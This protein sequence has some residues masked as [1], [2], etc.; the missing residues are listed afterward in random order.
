MTTARVLLNQGAATYRILRFE[1]SP[2]GSLIAIMDRDARPKRGGMRTNEKGIFVPDEGQSDLALP[3][4]RFSIHTTS[5]VHRYASG[6]RE[7]TIH[8]EPLPAPKKLAAIGFISIPR[9]SRLDLLDE[10][11]HK[12]DIATMLDIPEGISDRITFSLEIGPNPQEPQTYGVALNYEVYSAVVR[13]IPN[14]L[15]FP[16]EMA[17]H[18]I[19]GTPGEGQFDKRQIDH[20]QRR[21]G[22]L[23]T[24]TRPKRI[25]FPRG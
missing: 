7:N 18:F 20:G 4:A 25:Y 3:S 6:K 21:V 1:T 11:R 17:D 16:P 15:T 5:E 8:I 10:G 9:V 12:Y 13:V 2:D 23:S 24:H 19:H 14:F 22:V